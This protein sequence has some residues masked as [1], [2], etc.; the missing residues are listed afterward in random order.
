MQA[1]WGKGEEGRGG[2][3]NIVVVRGDDGTKGKGKEEEEA[4]WMGLL[5]YVHKEGRR[6]KER[7]ALPEAV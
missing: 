6:G 1:G 2:E 3:D 5:K 4:E 7:V